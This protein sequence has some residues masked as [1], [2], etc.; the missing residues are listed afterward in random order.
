MAFLSRDF[1]CIIQAL[2]DQGVD[3]T[4]T[5][6]QRGKDRYDY[7]NNTL[8]FNNNRRSFSIYP[9]YYDQQNWF[10]IP[11]MVILAHELNHCYDDLVNGV[12]SLGL[13]DDEFKRR[14]EISAMMMENT[15]RYGLYARAGLK[16]WPR[17]GYGPDNE[18][19]ADDIA[20]AWTRWNRN[21]VPKYP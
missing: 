19:V 3:I 9:I 18:D 1:A 20:Q 15:L 7:D 6:T 10:T 13:S 21:P 2:E 8:Y 11:S 12:T 4:I 16:I 5:Y 14:T 17:P